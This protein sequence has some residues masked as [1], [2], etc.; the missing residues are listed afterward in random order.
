MHV[1]GVLGAN[2]KMSPKQHVGTANPPQNPTKMSA[3]GI[4]FLIG[5][6]GQWLT[7]TWMTIMTL[8][9]NAQL[10]PR[11]VPTYMLGSMLSAHSVSRKPR[12]GPLSEQRPRKSA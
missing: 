1:E 7:Q 5:L 6:N 8:S 10:A 3:L 9:S 2:V 4:Q 12:T 11:E